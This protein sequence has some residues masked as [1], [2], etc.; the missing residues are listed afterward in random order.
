MRRFKQ[1][2][3]A[4][5]LFVALTIGLYLARAP[6]LTAIANA[7]IINDPLQK[8]D[9]IVVLGGGLQTRPFEAAK[10][11]RAG[12]APKILILNVKPLR[13]DELGITPR[14]VE[15]TRKILEMEH[16]PE[17]AIVAVGHD[18]HATWDDI[19][20]VRDWAMTNGRN[21]QLVE[22]ERDL[23]PAL[24]EAGSSKFNV[25]RST[26]VRT[27]VHRPSRPA[28]PTFTL[29]TPS[30]FPT[31]TL[32]PRSSKSPVYRVRFI[33]QNACTSSRPLPI[34][35]TNGV[36]SLKASARPAKSSACRCTRSSARRSRIESWRRFQKR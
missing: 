8:S 36:I 3:I 25:Q 11:Y 7:W 19:S 9:A 24:R 21:D 30:A 4:F 2:G 22:R 15:S 10:L 14:E 34:A 16:V 26:F 6:L 1:F 27:S 17:N 31:A 33:I 12:W 5:A 28:T 35:A 13:T 20:A 18:V 29:N 23:A 32:S